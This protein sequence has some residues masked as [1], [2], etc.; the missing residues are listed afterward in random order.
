MLNIDEMSRT[1]IQALLSQVD[2]G[3]LGCSLAGH[4]YVVPMNYCFAD[5]DLYLFTTEGMKTHYMDENPEVCLQV[6][7]LKDREH[8]RSAVV[9]GRCERIADQ[10]E[11]KR[12]TQAIKT[13]N[14]QLSPAINHTW[15][16]VWG[17]G[18]VVAIYRIHPSEMSGR[19]TDGLSS[20]SMNAVY[21]AALAK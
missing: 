10:E 2:Y 12:I 1:E 18:N 5:P 6:E 14:P 13:R 17:R 9:I 20:K 19:T 16:D 3:H 11:V 7:D 8:W 15:T 21:E 4:P